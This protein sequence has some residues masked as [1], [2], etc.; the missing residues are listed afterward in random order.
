MQN[1][2]HRLLRLDDVDRL[3]GISS[4]CV[5]MVNN[6]LKYNFVETPRKFIIAELSI[7]KLGSSAL[8]LALM[9]IR[10]YGSKALR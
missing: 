5:C 1:V 3:D 7:R 9:E 10:A 4:L 6:K 8:L 2:L